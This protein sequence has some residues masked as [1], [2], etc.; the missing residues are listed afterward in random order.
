MASHSPILVY[1]ALMEDVKRRIGCLRR[2]AY[3]DLSLGDERLNWEVSALQLRMVLESI[4]F[5][6]LSAHR[7]IYSRVHAK[8][9]TQVG[10]RF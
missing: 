9:A 8:F 5:A 6:S 10:A 3:A 1:Q 7:D 2:I 4:A